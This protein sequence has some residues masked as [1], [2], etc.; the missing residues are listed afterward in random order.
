[1]IH[2]RALP[3]FVALAL[4]A[5]A[6]PI[7]PT[8]AVEPD[9]AITLVESAPVETALA[10]ADIPAAHEVWLQMVRSA[11]RSLDIAEF[12]VSDE[13]GSRLSPIIA[14]I[15][16]AGQ[17]GVRVRF[18]VDD[19]FADKYPETLKQLMGQKGLE[20]RRLAV[21]PRM[22]GVQHAKYFVVDGREAYLGSQNFDWRSLEHIQEMGVR[23]R[24]KPIA[25][26]LL[27]VFETDWEL[28]GGAPDGTR[29]HRHPGVDPVRLS[30]GE[31]VTFVASPRHWLPEEDGWD[32]PRL[33]GLLDG[34][35]REIRVQLLTYKA[36][37][38]DGSPFLELDQ[39]LRRAA[40]RGVKVRLLVSDWSAKPGSEARRSVHAI[41]QVPGVE[42]RV[43]AIPPYSK[44]EVPFARV[45]HAKYLVVDQARSWVGT[46]NWE[47]DYF[48]KSRNVGVV[49]DDAAFSTRLSQVFED[50]WK[51]AYARPF[52]PTPEDDLPPPV[53]PATHS[54]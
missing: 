49:V 13:P 41:S 11:T 16:E 29:I 6:Q 8:A 24:S 3:L 19:S 33:V 46:S 38:Y 47:G 4:C 44:K 5:C 50:G 10:H 39:A 28:A 43:I 1:M 22:G 7:R 25:G 48:L 31:R 26:S 30:S 51:S 40:S 20:L 12:Y 45:C 35:Q 34:A 21:K 15:R 18:L 27:D 36:K 23:V 14:A 52:A 42:A 32:L 37:S 53:R 9:S 17:R 2:R 54:E